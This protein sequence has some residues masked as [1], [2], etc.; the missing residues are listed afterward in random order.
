[1]HY[2]IYSLYQMHESGGIMFCQIFYISVH[3]L[4]FLQ[5]VLSLRVSCFIRTLVI[6]CVMSIGYW[7]GPVTWPVVYSGN[8]PAV[9]FSLVAWKGCP[10]QGYKNNMELGKCCKFQTKR[11]RVICGSQCLGSPLTRNTSNQYNWMKTTY[12][13]I[14]T[15]LKFLCFII[16]DKKNHKH[17]NFS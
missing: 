3:Y 10:H 11:T 16:Y 5:I 14:I 13:K 9:C 12:R 2:L 1:M 17:S 8:I 4:W 6:L 7:N 15:I